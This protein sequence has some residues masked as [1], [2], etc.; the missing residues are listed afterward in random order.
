MMLRFAEIADAPALAEIYRYYVLNTNV[1]FEYDPPSVD[2]FARR[3]TEFKACYPYL[4]SVEDGAVTGYAYAHRYGERAAY[5]WNAELS[6]Y[7]RHDLRSRGTGR[8]LY[9]TLIDLVQRQNV[10]NV[11]G[12][13][14]SPNEPSERLHTAMGFILAGKIHRAGFKLGQW[15]DVGIWEK[16]VNPFEVPPRPLINFNEIMSRITLP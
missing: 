8:I 4:V 2:E 5:Q 15:L 7:V 10:K 6:V 3:M 13:V 11:Y 12:I 16:A 1:T 14:T 9:Q